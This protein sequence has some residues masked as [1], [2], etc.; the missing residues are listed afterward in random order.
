MA[1]TTSRKVPITLILGGML[2]GLSLDSAGKNVS[3][4]ISLIIGAALIVI[5]AMKLNDQKTSARSKQYLAG[6]L[7]T[8][9][10]A[11]GFY[12]AYVYLY[13]HLSGTG[14]HVTSLL[15]TGLIA[16]GYFYLVWDF[17]TKKISSNR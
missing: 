5:G 13:Q 9:I 11:I 1:K 7:L 16:L 12:K 15:G 3:A 10:G 17:T 14:P 4:T 2:F 6:V 8:L